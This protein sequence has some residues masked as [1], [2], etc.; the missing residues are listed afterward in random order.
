MFKILIFLLISPIE[1]S[2]TPFKMIKIQ[3]L[4]NDTEGLATYDFIVNNMPLSD[5]D[6]DFLT[7]NLLKKDKSGKYTASAIRFLISHDKEKLTPWI[8]RLID[9]IIQKDRER[10]YIGGLLEAVWGADYQDR[11]EEL[12]KDDKFRR[13]YKRV[14]PGDRV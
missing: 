13:I 14:Y 6:M 8:Y 12:N 4:E 5:N 10:R 7:D 3:D 9:G 1:R 11:V 2:K